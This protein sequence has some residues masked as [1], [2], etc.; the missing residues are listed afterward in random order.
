MVS[1]INSFS[2]QNIRVVV[3]SGSRDFGRC[4]LASRLPAALW[5]VAG[6]IVLETVLLQLADQGIEDVIVCS[7]QD[8]SLLMESIQL[9]NSISIEFL[10][11]PLPVGTAGSIREA[12]TGRDDSL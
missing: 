8:K 4:S 7:R 6:K 5:P 9:D 11:E 1:I 12:Y 10:D 3:I 2:K